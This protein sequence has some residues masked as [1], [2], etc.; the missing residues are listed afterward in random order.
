MRNFLYGLT[1]CL[2]ATTAVADPLRVVTDIAP[3][4]GLVARI[5]DGAGTPDLILRPGASPHGYALRPSEAAA[6]EAAD[7]VIHVGGGLT[8]WLDDALDTL[9]GD[10]TRLTLI[11]LPGTTTHSF[12]EG[13]TF[14][15][16]DHDHNH[17]DAGLDPHAWLDPLNG[18]LW[19]DHIADTLAAADPANATLYRANAAAGQAEIDSVITR[20][21]AA[22]APV[23]ETPF[24]VFHDAYQYFE[25]RFDLAAT[26]AISLADA[27][28]PGPARLA[29]IRDLIADQNIACVFS[30]P[31]FSDALIATVAGSNTVKTAILDP[32]GASLDPGPQFYIDLLETMAAAMI[33]CLTPN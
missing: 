1:L 9:A 4:H 18:R 5:M 29:Q 17:D 21:T 13:V 25:Y 14:D 27:N 22:V 12:R 6:L 32:M 24:I 31:Q 20:M 8:P 16:H 19:L 30:E 3:V 7:V 26:A 33:P 28:A 2:F 11:E 10:A 23:R 15:A